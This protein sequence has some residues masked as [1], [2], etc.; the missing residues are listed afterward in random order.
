M[1]EA[2]QVTFC[3]HFGAVCGYLGSFIKQDTRSLVPPAIGETVKPQLETEP[4]HGVDSPRYW[5]SKF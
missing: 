1:M 2:P 4:D 5:C 3:C